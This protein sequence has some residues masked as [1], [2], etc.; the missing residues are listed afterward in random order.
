MVT[1]IKLK[2]YHDFVDLLKKKDNDF[3][4]SSL[5]DVTSGELP[6]RVPA[7]RVQE[8]LACENFST[9]YYTSSA[10]IK[11]DAEAL[12]SLVGLGLR[13]N[14]VKSK[15]VPGCIFA[16]VQEDGPSGIRFQRE[17]LEASDR[18]LPTEER[19]RRTACD[20]KLPTEERVLRGEMHV[21]VIADMDKMMQQAKRISPKNFFLTCFG[22]CDALEAKKKSVSCNVEG[23]HAASTFN[24][25]L[26]VEVPDCCMASSLF[27][28]AFGLGMR[29]TFVRGRAVSGCLVLFLLQPEAEVAI[30]TLKPKQQGIGSSSS[31]TGRGSAQEELALAKRR[32]TEAGTPEARL[33]LLPPRSAGGPAGVAQEQPRAVAAGKATDTLEDE[34]SEEVYLRQV[35]VLEKR[36]QELLPRLPRE[37]LAT[38]YVQSKLEEHM[39][40]GS[41]RLSKFRMDIFRVW[42]AYL[43]V[44]QASDVQDVD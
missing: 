20:R 15:N 40:L 3:W 29:K 14:K 13:K 37:Q 24:R 41:G 10:D 27:T 26:I 44:T 22:G 42:R 25:A 19:I 18:R 30:S 43:E 1:C 33:C 9:C 35:R 2:R 16:L 36:L 5:A 31:T 8:A 11:A 4:I 23:K 12:I 17:H 21:E 28:G 6:D 7:Y 34:R 38:T 39:Q 32:R